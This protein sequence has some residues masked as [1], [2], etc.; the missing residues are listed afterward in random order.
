MEGSCEF[1][2]VVMAVRRLL[3]N[4]WAGDREVVLTCCMISLAVC[5]STWRVIVMSS[6]VITTFMGGLKPMLMTKVT[7]GSHRAAA[8][9]FQALK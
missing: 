2:R 3:Q 9:M 8:G 7:L 5:E 6:F 4:P 1:E